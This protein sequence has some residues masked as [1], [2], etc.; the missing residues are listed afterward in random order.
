VADTLNTAV[1]ATDA[2]GAFRFSGV[3]AGQYSLEVATV[4]GNRS[5]VR[6]PVNV[7]GDTADVSVVLEPSGEFRG[8]LAFDGSAREPALAGI[9]TVRALLYPLSYGG[10]PATAAFDDA[11]VLS[12]GGLAP[13]DYAVV[14]GSMPRP[15]RL[16]RVASTGQPKRS[17]LVTI[18]A[19]KTANVVLEVTARPVLLSGSVLRDTTAP[20]AAQVI[21]LPEDHQQW[22]RAG[23]LALAMRTAQVEEDGSF[24]FEGIPEGRYLLRA[25]PADQIVSA[26][27]ASDI[28]ALVARATAVS[29]AGPSTRINV[30]VER[31]RRPS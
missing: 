11:G 23:R 25:V 5:R 14:L 17:A 24:V 21:L 12:V 8:R 4:E 15:W 1:T 16:D 19:G 18:E 28:T 30:A 6:M 31:V 10:R 7:S 9:R 27:N 26:D 2:L 13:G 20:A 3:P 22:L 29:V